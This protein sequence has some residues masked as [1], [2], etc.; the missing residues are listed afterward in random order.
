MLKHFINVSGLFQLVTWVHQQTIKFTYPHFAHSVIYLLFT[1][2]ILGSKWY[3][4]QLFTSHGACKPLDKK[5]KLNSSIES[6]TSPIP[7]YNS[8][9]FCSTFIKADK[10]LKKLT[11]YD[12][13][14]KLHW[15]SFVRKVNCINGRYILFSSIFLIILI[16]S[17]F[18]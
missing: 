9:L 8:I 11:I 7:W 13:R 3:I 12:I 4:Y 17:I 2:F 6:P 18:L 5:F 16:F 1:Y 14:R 15:M 10:S